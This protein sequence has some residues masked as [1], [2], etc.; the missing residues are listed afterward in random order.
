MNRKL[1]LEFKDEMDQTWRLIINDP[2]E[3]LDSET[4]RS[5]MDTILETN[6]LHNKGNDL[7]MIKKAY[8]I[9]Q[10]KT[11]YIEQE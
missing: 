11:D 3:D 8:E 10:V 9:E 2:K 4:I 1:Y 6:A 7:K 5:N